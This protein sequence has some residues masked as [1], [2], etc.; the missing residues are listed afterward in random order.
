M[1]TIILIIF[2][3]LLTITNSC[4]RSQEN[5][6]EIKAQNMLLEFYSKLFYIYENDSIT[7]SV[8]ADVRHKKLDSLI[9]IYCTT[10]LSNKAQETLEDGY[11]HDLLTNDLIGDLNENLKVEKDSGKENG[12][13]V[14]FKAMYS[15]ATRE[16]LPKQVFLHVTLVK[17]GERYKIDLVE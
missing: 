15:D 10:R 1:K 4:C 11:G 13:I 2:S 9:R 3:A 17:E 7:T 8:P 6:Q 14:S 5:V 12:Y 16:T